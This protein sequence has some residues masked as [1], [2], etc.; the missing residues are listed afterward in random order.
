MIILEI[1]I[2][3]VSALETKCQPTIAAYLY[4][5]FALPISFQKVKTKSREVQ[6]AEFFRAIQNV[7]ADLNALLHI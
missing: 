1:L 3:D 2:Q 4:S 5:E 6:I 7:Q